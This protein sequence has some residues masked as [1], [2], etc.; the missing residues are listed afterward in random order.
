M[1]DHGNPIP[2]SGGNREHEPLVTTDAPS[3]VPGV[4]Q[5]DFDM[6]QTITG[7]AP[8]SLADVV[9]FKKAQAQ[10]QKNK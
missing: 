10:A 6:I 1:A 5:R 3:R 9:A 2:P 7:E 4:T 8:K